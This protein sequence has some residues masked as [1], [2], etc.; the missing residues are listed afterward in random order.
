MLWI[1]VQNVN[2]PSAILD[3][4]AFQVGYYTPTRTTPMIKEWIIYVSSCLLSLHFYIHHRILKFRRKSPKPY[5]SHRYHN[6]NILYRS[7][8]P[9]PCITLDLDMWTWISQQVNMY[10]KVGQIIILTNFG[11]PKAMS[12]DMT[13][14]D[15]RMTS[16][17]NVFHNVQHLPQQSFL[18]TC[19]DCV[20]HFYCLTSNDLL[21][22]T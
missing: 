8:Y 7:F 22:Y 21:W 1:L 10:I 3:G 9:N 15:P 14:N 6:H 19:G 4:K 5:P 2:C 11:V 17:T 18:T 13:S 16:D 20:S 12:H